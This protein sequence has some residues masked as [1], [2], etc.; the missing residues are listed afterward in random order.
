MGATHIQVEMR[1]DTTNINIIRPFHAL[2]DIH[3]VYRVLCFRRVLYDYWQQDCNPTF[4]LRDLR[5]LLDTPL[6]A[7]DTIKNKRN[8]RFTRSRVLAR[9]CIQDVRYYLWVVVIE[10]MFGAEGA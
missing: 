4:S 5:N 8:T 7:S 9:S 3:L 1:S 10:C 2:P 6:E